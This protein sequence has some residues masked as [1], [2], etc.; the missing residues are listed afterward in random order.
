MNAPETQFDPASARFGSSRSQKRIEDN[1]LLT[2]KVLTSAYHVPVV[3][4]FIR[5]VLTNTMATG[6]YRGAGRPE[7]N[8]LMERLLDQAA[9]EMELDPAEI[10]WRNFI[11]PAAF[12]YRTHLGDTY[13]AGEFARILGRVLKASDWDNFKNRK[14]ESQRRGRLRGR[15]LASYLEWTGALPTETVDIERSRPTAR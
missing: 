5:G 8:F 1:R 11:A 12:P 15:G 7:G 6:A 4:Y 10:R 13:D 2:G 3:D 14:E 9:R